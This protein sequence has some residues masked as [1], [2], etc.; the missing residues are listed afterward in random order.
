MATAQVWVRCP[1]LSP[2]SNQHEPFETLELTMRFDP[3][4]TRDA[5]LRLLR[6]E[7]EQAYGTG[8]LE[9]LDPFLEV[10]ATALWRLG[11]A[12]LDL[13]DDEPDRLAARGPRG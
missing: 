10:T 7:A 11:T 13:M 12:P 9:E 4:A 6:D 1:D 5:V 3:T 8:R 2:A